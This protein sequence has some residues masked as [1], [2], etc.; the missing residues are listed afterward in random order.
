MRTRIAWLIGV[1]GLFLA[2]GC[3]STP[4]D[5]AVIIES[6]YQVYDSVEDLWQEADLVV[7]ATV[8]PDR[9]VTRLR[10]EILGADHPDYNNP[11]ADPLAG[12]TPEERALAE[13]ELR[14]HE[15]EVY[16]VFDVRITQVWQGNAS[17]GETFQV[18][19]PGGRLAGVDYIAA[20]EVALEADG[21]YLLFLKVYDSSP[22]MMLNPQQAQ[23]R[24]GSGAPVA[25]AE[26]HV[27][28]TLG[29]LERLADQ[30]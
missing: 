9:S 2:A 7:E 6:E 30:G 15:G 19:Q 1:T 4:D 17:V 16:T 12:L 11:A 10:P 26:N 22:A 3:S 14:E 20:E 5:Q 18:K 25:L 23:Y 24:L 28:V 21:G 13:A 8:G 29:D 27:E